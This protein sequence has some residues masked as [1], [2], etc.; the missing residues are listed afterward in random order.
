MV[1]QSTITEPG[2]APALSPCSPRITSCDI[3]VL[4]TQRKVYW[5]RRATSSGVPADV[6]PGAAA[7]NFSA[8]LRL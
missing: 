2:A 4:P 3:A 7:A 6:A 8:F 5:L 1:L